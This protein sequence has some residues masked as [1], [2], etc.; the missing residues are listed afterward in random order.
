MR[1]RGGYTVAVIDQTGRGHA[2]VKRYSEDPNVKRV[3]AIPGNALMLANASKEVKIFPTY[4]GQKV[5]TASIAP[6]REICIKEEVNVLDVTQ[7]DAVEAGV[8]DV[9]REIGILTVGPSREAGKIEWDKAFSRD[10]SREAGIPIPDYAVFTSEKSV[11]PYLKVHPDIQRAIKAAHL[12]GGKGVSSARNNKEARAKIHELRRRFPLAARK[13]LLE[14]WMLNDDGT[15]GE[16][17]SAFFICD[18]TNWQ[19]LGAAQDYKL[20][21]CEDRGENTGSMGGNSPTLIYTK[22]I[23][24]QTE[25]IADKT[26]SELRKKGTPYQG[27]LYVS[28]IIVSERGQKIVKVIEHNARWGD[29]EGQLLIEGIENFLEINLAA[30]RGDIRNVG[31]KTD[32]KKRVAIAGAA[33]GY[34]GSYDQVIGKRI[35]GL[36]EILQIN[37]VNIYG[38]GTGI[39]DGNYFVNGANGRLFHAV[40]DGET[41]LDARAKGLEAISRATIEGNNLHF[42]H[43]TAWRD[44]ERER[45]TA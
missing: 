37:G 34:P 27:V 17:F 42:R 39:D 33:R 1:E 14:E 4:N 20:S 12:T 11:L 16:E 21:E 24:N 15:P 36:K 31:V 8:A 29:P 41:F 22:E 13:Y 23:A 2:A 26:F 30:A 32:G 3:L 18:G 5:T 38:A 25:E 44:I 45:K 10:L 7:D 9:G 6:I 28:A 19:F 43:D 35:D 40:T